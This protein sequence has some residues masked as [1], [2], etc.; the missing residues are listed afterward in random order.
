MNYFIK[1]TTQTANK[2]V[3]ICTLYASNREMDAQSGI[4]NF[5]N[6]SSPN[7]FALAALPTLTCLMSMRNPKFDQNG[8]RS[9]SG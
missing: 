5:M 4:Q 6:N 3:E 9:Y 8:K 7:R 2:I 1:K